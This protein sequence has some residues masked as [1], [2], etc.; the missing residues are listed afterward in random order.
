M[1]HNTYHAVANTERIAVSLV[2]TCGD[3]FLRQD[4]AYGKTLEEIIDPCLHFPPQ[5]ALRA[6]GNC[7]RFKRRTST[8]VDAFKYVT[9]R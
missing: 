4:I 1:M 3:Y 6:S 5:F 8:R 9:V 2:E 7:Q